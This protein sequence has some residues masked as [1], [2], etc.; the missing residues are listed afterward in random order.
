MSFVRFSVGNTRSSMM[1]N[2]S[3]ML[4]NGYESEDDLVKWINHQYRQH[5]ALH[6]PEESSIEEHKTPRMPCSRVEA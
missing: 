6:A 2:V 4:R 5:H 3:S 1:R